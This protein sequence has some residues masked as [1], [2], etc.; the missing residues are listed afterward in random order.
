MEMIKSIIVNNWS[1]IVAAVIIVLGFKILKTGARLAITVMCVA[2]VISILTNVGIIPP[3]DEIFAGIK[4]TF[5]PSVS[6]AAPM[7]TFEKISF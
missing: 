3:L 6:A 5:Q 1:I 2:L 4:N 7:L